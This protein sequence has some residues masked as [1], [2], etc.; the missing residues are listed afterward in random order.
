MRGGRERER[1]I[2]R[3]RQE[4]EREKNQPPVPKYH[5]PFKETISLKSLY[6]LNC[7]SPFC[8]IT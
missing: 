8:D 6:N 2:E 7:I 5:H 3:Q 4:R 1:E